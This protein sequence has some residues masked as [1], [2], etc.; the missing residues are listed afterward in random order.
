MAPS[1]ANIFMAHLE[2]QLLMSVSLK[3]HMWLRFIDD[4]DIQWRHSHKDLQDFLEKANTFYKSI[5]FTSEISNENHIYLDTV[6][7]IEGSK[8]VTDMY[9]KPTDIHQCLL[10]TSC[11]PRNCCKNIPYGIALK[12]RRICSQGVDYERRTN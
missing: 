12:R 5:T 4:I 9:L 8:L 11:H 10:P 1:Y 6:S 3:P 2:R 7:P